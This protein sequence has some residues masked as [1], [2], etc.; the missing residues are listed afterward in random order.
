MVRQ[1]HHERDQIPLALSQ[2]KGERSADS[3]SSA[4]IVYV[5]ATLVLTWPL[6][7]GLTHDIPGDFGDPLFT[8]WVLSWD[9]T[10]LGPGWWSANIFHPHPLSLAYSEHFLPQ[11]LTVAPVFYLTRNPILCYNL[12]FL[13]SFVLAG[14]GTFLLTRELT[15]ST[16]AA[17]IGGLLFAFA[18]YRIAQTS[19]L[20]VLSAQWM[21][22]TLWAFSRYVSDRKSTRLNSSH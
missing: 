2:S 18:P 7:R 1:A 14:V 11:A 5:L 12:L 10:H 15:G 9:L 13:S 6:A 19:H 21:P 4:F 20:H 16:R 17:F 22:F 3:A 8:M